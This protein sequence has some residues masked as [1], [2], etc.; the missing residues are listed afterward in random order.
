MSTLNIQFA[1]S[2]PVAAPS[3][4][5]P[6]LRLAGGNGQVTQAIRQITEEFLPVIAESR[7]MQDVL[8][9]IQ[10]EES[11]ATPLVMVGEAGAGK[12]FLARLLHSRGQYAT[13][14]FI[15]VDVTKLAVEAVDQ[16]LLGYWHKPLFGRAELVPGMLAEAAGGTLVIRGLETLP[17]TLQRLLLS[18]FVDKT[19]QPIGV[20]DVLPVQ[21]RIAMIFGLPVFPRSSEKVLD[22]Q[23]WEVLKDRV[24]T[25]PSL[26]NRRD[27]ILPLTELFLERTARDWNQ[28]V[29]ELSAAAQK[30]LKRY[31]WAGNAKELQWALASAVTS[32]AHQVLDVAHFPPQ[33]A[34]VGETPSVESIALEDFIEQKLAQFLERVGNYDVSDLHAAIETQMERPLFKLVLQHTQGNQIKAARILG[35]N[36]NTLRTKLKKYGLK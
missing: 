8:R 31:R 3:P 29:R 14:P 12:Q 25:V 15:T 35:I 26:Q 28:P 27:D 20:D 1:E 4:E 33:F 13:G 32:T 22:P 2:L 7:A 6:V 9:Q 5:A 10:D 18:A 19:Y 30:M 11:R 34:T 36:R 21:C 16:I 17:W 24:V 23:I